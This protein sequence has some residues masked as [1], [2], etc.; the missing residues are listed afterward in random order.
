MTYFDSRPVATRRMAAEDA[1]ILVRHG[2]GPDNCDALGMREASVVFHDGLYYL[3][4]DGAKPDHGWRACLATSTDLETWQFHGP[5]LELGA[6]GAPD[7]GSASA[8][9]FVQDAG[10][11]HMYYL[12]CRQVSAKPDCIPTPP[13]VTLKAEA[14]SLSGPWQKRYDLAPFDAVPGTYYSETASPGFVVRH[15][16][17]FLMFFS[18]AAGVVVDVY[19]CDIQR[20][21]GLA[22]TRDL[23]CPWQVDLRPVLPESEQIENSSLYFEGES[24]RWFLFTN[25]IGIDRRGEYTDAIWVYWSENLHEWDPANKAIVL[26]GTNCLW[27]KVCI[28]MPSVIRVGNR[29]AMFYDA[30]G[31]GSHSHMHRDIGLAWIDLPLIVPTL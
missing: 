24:N 17:E 15:N 28:G 5:V 7:S 25:H 20:T 8:P 3:F 16:Q 14:D 22:R 19:H 31:G 30:P 2:T 4:Y 6:A 13:Y 11:W 10:R 29:L 12:G 27:S 18:A 9:W 21:L 26:D 23:G 1:G